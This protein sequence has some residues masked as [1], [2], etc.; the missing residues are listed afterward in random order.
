M[1]ELG[2]KLKRFFNSN[3]AYKILDSHEK[4]KGST[5]A[6]GGCAV[7][8]VALSSLLP[9]SELK[10]VEANQKPQH[11][12][13]AYQGRYYDSY[14]G[15]DTARVLEKSFAKRE[16]FSSAKVV[17]FSRK[18]VEEAEI[19]CPVELVVK[20]RQELAKVIRP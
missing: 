11:V 2:K 18:G 14:G 20:L 8:A 17:S 6:A 7:A 13:V 12:V 19:V 1:D 10:T 15:Y 5:W 9:G 4:T 3:R 16:G